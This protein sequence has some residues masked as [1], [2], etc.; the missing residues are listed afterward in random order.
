MKV[1]AFKNIMMLYSDLRIISC[2]FYLRIGTEA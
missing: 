2:S 1:A